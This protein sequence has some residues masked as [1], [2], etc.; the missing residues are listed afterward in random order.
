MLAREAR[1]DK[2]EILWPPTPAYPYGTPARPANCP[3]NR[4]WI[5]PVSVRESPRSLG[6][7]RCYNPSLVLSPYVHA[8]S[9]IEGPAMRFA[10]S[11]PRTFGVFVAAMLVI[12]IAGASLSSAQNAQWVAGFGVP[13]MNGTDVWGLIEYNGG[14]V[15]C[16]DFTTAGGIPCNYVAFWDGSTWSP[17]G[18]GLNGQADGVAPFPWTPNLLSRRC[19]PCPDPTP[20]TP[21]SFGGR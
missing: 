5:V 10:V 2:E 15:A 4:F 7:G 21:L 17:L 6:A 16:G 1:S 19:S 18:S 8:F 14:V 3:P 13:G 9:T 12:E 20:P 11:R